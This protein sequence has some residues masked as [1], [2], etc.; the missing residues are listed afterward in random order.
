MKTIRRDWLKRQI[1]KGNIEAKCN[2]KFTDDYAFDN[3]YNFGKTDWMPARIKHP[4]YETYTNEIGS[5]LT[6][7]TDDDLK[8]GYLNFR[9]DDFG[10]KSGM[11]YY[12][13][14][15]SI[16][17]SVLSSESYTLRVKAVQA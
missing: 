4:Q 1:E 7:R 9:E 10:Y 3:A 15:G 16:H 6:R 17:F 12:N 5:V 2:H 14:D 13:D 8:D 11:A